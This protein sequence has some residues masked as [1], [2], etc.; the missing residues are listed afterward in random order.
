L[1]H[2]N[3]ISDRPFLTR[4][5][6]EVPIIAYSRTKN[7]SEILVRARLPARDDVEPVP[8]HDPRPGSPTLHMLEDLALESRGLEDF[9]TSNGALPDNGEGFDDIGEVSSDFNDTEN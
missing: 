6:P 9:F 5:F 7:L 1:K 3:I 8:I 2:W 4:L